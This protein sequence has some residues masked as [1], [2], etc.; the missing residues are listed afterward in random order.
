M[1]WEYPQRL[2]QHC[3]N[4]YSVYRNRVNGALILRSAEDFATSQVYIGYSIREAKRMFRNY[5]KE[6]KI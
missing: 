2:E 3:T 4:K 6:I 5:L 1:T